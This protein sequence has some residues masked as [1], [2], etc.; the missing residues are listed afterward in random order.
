M[1]LGMDDMLWLVVDPSP[2]SEMDDVASEVT[3]RQFVRMLAGGMSLNDNPVFFTTEREAEVEAFG[4]MT[5]MRAA[6]AIARS[7][8][9][10]K[11]EKA[12]RLEIFGADGELLF[13]ADLP[14]PRGDR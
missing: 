7:G 5:A 8:K 4:R 12:T 6:Q 10:S 9:G 3:L 1:K 11:L 13:E 2:N 14:R